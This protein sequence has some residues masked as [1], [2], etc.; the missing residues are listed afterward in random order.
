MKNEKRKMNNIE[1]GSN[2]EVVSDYQNEYTIKLRE[3][4]LDFSVVI[5][6]FLNTLPLKREYDVLKYQLSK[7]ATAIGANYEEAQSSTYK[8]FI[9]KVRIALR[10]ANETKYWLEIIRRLN[11]G[12]PDQNAEL[13]DEVNQLSL[14]LGSIASKADKKLRGEK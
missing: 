10:E 1:F 11:A 14:I 7:S 5:I 6:Q 12:N 4:F 9:Q 13:I 2:S 3:R 8:E